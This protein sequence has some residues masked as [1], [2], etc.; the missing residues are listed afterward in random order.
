MYMAGTISSVLSLKPNPGVVW[1]ISP[2]ETVFRALEL[3]AEKN[4]GALIVTEGEKIVGMMSERDYTRKVALR[5]KTQRN[6]GA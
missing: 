4:V 3:L 6:P 2:D 1:S 5:G